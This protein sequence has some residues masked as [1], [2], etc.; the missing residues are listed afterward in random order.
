MIICLMRMENKKMRKDVLLY[1]CD[2][3]Y[4]TWTLQVTYPYT[5]LWQLP[6]LKLGQIY[7]ALQLRFFV[8]SLS[9]WVNARTVQETVLPVCLNI[10]MVHCTVLLAGWEYI[11]ISTCVSLLASSIWP[12]G[13]ACIRWKL[14]FLY[15]WII[16]C[17]PQIKIWPPVL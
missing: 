2:F 17:Y 7:W 6:C 16:N 1:R 10:V 11:F 4:D 8:V 14:K 5:W 15:V 3:H 9:L 12:P 13:Q